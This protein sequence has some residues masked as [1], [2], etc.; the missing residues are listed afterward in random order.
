[1]YVCMYVC[2]YKQDLTLNNLQSLIC[3]K[4]QP[5]KNKCG[6]EKSMPHKANKKLSLRQSNPETH[7]I[8]INRERVL[9]E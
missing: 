5:T 4:N 3:H 2:M 8:D 9:P 1:M 6:N 7:C